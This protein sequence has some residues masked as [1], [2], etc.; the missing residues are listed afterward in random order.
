MSVD[1]E[2]N[3][4]YIEEINER[5]VQNNGENIRL[6]EGQEEIALTIY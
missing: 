2:R 3:K 6:L 1:V 5:D 4:V